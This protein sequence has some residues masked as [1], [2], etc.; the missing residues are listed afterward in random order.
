MKFQWLNATL[1]YMS[2]VSHFSLKAESDQL[3]VVDAY[4]SLEL[5]DQSKKCNLFAF[6]LISIKISNYKC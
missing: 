1:L 6:I 5:Y 2:Y 3:L 4:S